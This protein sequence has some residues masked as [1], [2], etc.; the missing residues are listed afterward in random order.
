MTATGRKA[1][2]VHFLRFELAPEMIAELKAG[3]VLEFGVSHPE[4]AF[5]V[6]DIPDATRES[7]I[8]DLD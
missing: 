2:S 1:S 5:A 6:C 8:A 7:L 3:A 4:F